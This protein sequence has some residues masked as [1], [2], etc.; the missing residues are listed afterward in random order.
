MDIEFNLSTSTD[1]TSMKF[2]IVLKYVKTNSTHAVSV[3]RHTSMGVDC[4]ISIP[5]QKKYLKE[6]RKNT[7]EGGGT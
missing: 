3:I 6:K 4:R 1:S 7:I 2:N 5:R